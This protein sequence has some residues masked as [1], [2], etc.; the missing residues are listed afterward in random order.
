VV[1]ILQVEIKVRAQKT[2][3]VHLKCQVECVAGYC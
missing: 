3:A 1:K 2:S